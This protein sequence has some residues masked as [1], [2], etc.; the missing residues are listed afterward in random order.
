VR[1]ARR[2][3]PAL[4]HDI[5]AVCCGTK[6]LIEIRCPSDCG[7]LSSSRA[8][9]AA[10]TVRQRQRDFALMIDALR[11][12]NERQS[13][14]LLVLGTDAARHQ[15][16]GLHSLADVDFIEA[17]EAL[18]ATLETAVRGVIYEHRPASLPALRLATA[19][20]A[21]LKEVGSGLAGFDRDAA[22]VLRRLEAAARST[23]ATSPDAPR[24]FLDLLGRLTA[25]VT[26]EDPAG[27]AQD[28][29]R[30]I[31]P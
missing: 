2:A 11:D 30:L 6:R 19:L 16:E 3:C 24:A 12:L 17:A 23:H 15:P 25:G 4:G 31:V 5:C 22:I 27:P 28:E 1:R 18:A 21:R 9:P 26:S 29:P 10:A 7:Y 8:H 20:A 14:L 13:R